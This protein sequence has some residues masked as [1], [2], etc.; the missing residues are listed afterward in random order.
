MDDTTQNKETTRLRNAAG[1]MI[2]DTD[3]R[4]KRARFSMI[5][6]FIP[7]GTLHEFGGWMD[8]VQDTLVRRKAIKIIKRLS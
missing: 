8:V 5:S 3:R 4:E 6:V 7:S 1:Y 2:K